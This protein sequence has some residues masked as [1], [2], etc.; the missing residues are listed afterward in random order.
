[1]HCY[2]YKSCSATNLAL[3]LNKLCAFAEHQGR[4]SARWHAGDRHHR[5]QAHTQG[6]LPVRLQPLHRVRLVQCLYTFYR[7]AAGLVGSAV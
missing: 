7:Q 3:T 1:M 4:V 5:G 6:R 2:H